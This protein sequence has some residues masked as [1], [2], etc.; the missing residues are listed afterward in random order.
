[1]DLENSENPVSHLQDE[2]N[3][4]GSNNIEVQ[5]S[6]YPVDSQQQGSEYV[7][8][9]SGLEEGL[10]ANNQDYV[11]GEEHND[12]YN[13]EGSGYV[14]GEQP[15]EVIE[16]RGEDGEEEYIGESYDPSQQHETN[17]YQE[18][19][20]GQESHFEDNT[21]NMESER[22]STHKTMEN[23]QRDDSDHIEKKFSYDVK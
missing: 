14:S 1:M 17:Q 22:I 8:D 21:H 20:P 16:E 23:R 12:Q 3:P 5:E 7:V 6:G 18:S 13:E 2:T 4:E 11:S 10:Y 9:S 15:N 19:Y